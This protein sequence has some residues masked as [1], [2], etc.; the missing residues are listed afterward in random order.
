[1]P[2]V[3]LSLLELQILVAL[4]D[5]KTLTQIAQELFLKHPSISRAL[6]SAEQ[7]TGVTLAEHVGRRLHLTSAGAELAAEARALLAHYEDL[8]SLVEDLRTGEAGTL[9]LLATRTA[10]TYLLPGVLREF[11]ELFDRANVSVQVAAPAELWERFANER[12]DLAVGPRTHATPPSA[13]WLFNDQDA[14]FVRPDDPLARMRRDAR[15][16]IPTLIAPIARERERNI[17][18][19]LR[20]AHITVGRRLDIRSLET[21]RQLVEAGV[22]AGL[23]DRS[24]VARPVAEERLVELSWLTLELCTSWYVAHRGRVQSPLVQRMLGLLQREARQ[25]RTTCTCDVQ[26]SSETGAFFGA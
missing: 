15:L 3:R 14:L 2:S 17:D 20:A 12:H 9:R 8:D 25:W 11:L 18:D 21:A 7:K 4:G 24:T 1:M 22:G 23:F 10:S 16:H 6:H 26:V 13:E 5:H 19:H